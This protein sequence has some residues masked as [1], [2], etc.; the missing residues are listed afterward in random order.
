MGDVGTGV[1]DGATLTTLAAPLALESGDALDACDVAYTVYGELNANKDNVVLVGH[2]LTSNS[3]VGEWWGEVLGE[4]D[5]YALNSRE[6]CV[7]CVNYLG[8]PYGSASPVSAD[9]RKED[10]GAYG[11]DFRRRSR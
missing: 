11:V 8:S 6:D 2:S 9:P 1:P 10:R 4:G 7:I 3:N 5:A